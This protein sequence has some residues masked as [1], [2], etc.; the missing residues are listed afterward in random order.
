MAAKSGRGKYLFHLVEPGRDG[1]CYFLYEK[2]RTED[3]KMW[4]DNAFV[5]LIDEYG[6]EHCRKLFK[7][8]GN[9]R[10]ENKV[11]APPDIGVFGG[12]QA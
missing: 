8:D 9:I 5:G 2:S 11:Q 10:R 12:A 6:A 7:G 1:Q 3:T 4:L